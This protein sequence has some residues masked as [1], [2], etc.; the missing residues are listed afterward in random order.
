ME[1]GAV[2]DLLTSKLGLTTGGRSSGQKLN[3]VEKDGATGH[4]CWMVRL[5]MP[6]RMV[7]LA[8]P[9]RMVRLAM[10]ART[11]RLAMPTRMVRLAMPARTV[12]LAMPA[13]PIK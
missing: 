11:V 6:A 10:P 9:A 7:R 12:R 5:A 3:K 4:A 2:T 1:E 13:R 8:M